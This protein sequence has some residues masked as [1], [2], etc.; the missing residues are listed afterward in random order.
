[1]RRCRAMNDNAAARVDDTLSTSRIA[2]IAVRRGDIDRGSSGVHNETRPDAAAPGRVYK[3][4]GNVSLN[5]EVFGR[6]ASPIADDLVFDLLAF[7]Q[8]AQS[9]SLNGGNV[10]EYVLAA[11]AGRLN[12]PISFGRIEPLHGACSHV[13]SPGYEVITVTQ[14]ARETK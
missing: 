12:E 13:T 11:S 8:R 14:G 2:I 3:S 7:A 1:M 4:L 10:H 9:G 5:L 6:L